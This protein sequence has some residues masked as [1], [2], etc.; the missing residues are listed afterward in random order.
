[1]KGEKKLSKTAK[2]SKNRNGSINVEGKLI[3][4]LISYYNLNSKL[5]MLCVFNY[6]VYFV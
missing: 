4:I 2:L 5:L 1:M 6:N 3:P